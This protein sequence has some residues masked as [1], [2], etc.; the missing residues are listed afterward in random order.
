LGLDGGT[1]LYMET[2]RWNHNCGAATVKVEKGSTFPAVPA[3][4]IVM[5]AYT[6]GASIV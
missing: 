3:S 2:S 5:E 4:Q 1:L 6:T